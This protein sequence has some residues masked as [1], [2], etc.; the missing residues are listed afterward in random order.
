VKKL[1][2]IGGPPRSGTTA[3][4]DYLNRHPGVLICRE[5]YK[6]VPPY[7][8]RPKLFTFERILDYRMSS[9][10]DRAETNTPREHHVKLLEGKDP[11]RLEWIGD[12]TPA[13]V[14][15][16]TRLSENSPGASFI[17]T[18]RPLEEV[19][20][21]FEARSKDPNDPWR[22]GGFEDG[23]ERWNA[24]M[25]S[26]RDFVE[27]AR[28]LNVL[29]VDYRTFFSDN[30]SVVPL[31]SRFLSIEI[32]QETQDAWRN[33]SRDFEA[34][35]RPKEPLNDHQRAFVEAEKDSEAERWVLN[36]IERQQREL[37]IYSPEAAREMAEERRLS[38]VRVAKERTRARRLR[39]RAESLQQEKE[40]LERQLGDARSSKGRRR[41]WPR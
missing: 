16:L 24:A 21:S 13:Y 23:V 28:N 17:V 30:R 31:L 7:E 11:E 32:D 33:L 8:V 4:A 40:E 41:L 3:L 22:L 5:R 27:S 10:G 19:A 37:K 20:E 1:L 26:V 25:R 2:F 35:R 15:I 18:Y 9:R 36:R 6:W 34:R 14:E 29:I 38:A 12:K 39:E